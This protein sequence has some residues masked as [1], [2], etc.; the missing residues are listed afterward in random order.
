MAFQPRFQTLVDI[1]RHATKEYGQNPLFGVKKGGTW[2]WSTYAEFAKSVDALRGGLA[3]VGVVKGDRVA[4]IANNRPEWAI[5]AYASYGLGAQFVPMYESQLDKDWKFILENCGAKVVFAANEGIRDRIQSFRGDLPKLEQLVVIDGKGDDNS[6]GWEDLLA[7]GE[8]KPAEIV[9]VSPDD[10]AGFIYTSGTTGMPKGVL[11]THKNLAYNVSAIHDV[12]P[13]SA[14]DRSL[15]FLPWAHSFGQTVELHGLFSMGASLGI[16]EAVDK[17]IVNLA[18]VQPTLLVSVPRIFNKIYDGLQKRMADEGGVK[19][20]LFD[21]AIANEDHRRAL[22]A[23]SKSSG[24]A[25]FKHGIFDKL[26]FSKV[27]DRFGGRLKY[28][29]SGG[30][31]INKDIA[32]FIDNLGITVYEGYGLTETSPIATANWPGSRRI[33]SI[34]KPIPGVEVKIDKEVTK[35]PVNGE[36]VVYGHNIMKGYN[37]LPEEDAKVFTDDG[38]FRTGD[39]GRI[40]DDGFVYITGRIKEQYKLENG[41]YVVPGPLEEQLK[42]SPFIASVM[43][44]GMNK[45]FNVA[46]IVPDM[47]SLEKWGKDN[48]ITGDLLTDP[49]V[50]ELMTKELDEHSSGF[51]QFEKVRKFKLIAEDFTTENDMLTPTMKLKRRIV[52]KAYG[53]DLDALYG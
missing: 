24:W 44:N 12:F 13:M 2:N 5:G 1:Y 18:E 23:E 40:D 45:P 38:G 6:I 51:K 15:S 36:I 52:M 46:I 16:A 14:D 3:D 8:E 47:V 10:V 22:A 30:A 9:D 35:D 25:D 17:I 28:A 19:K 31:A 27:R 20:A 50:A 7:R 48:G 53:D 34:G 42:L 39:M 11:L 4:I 33:G 21:A 37:E 41:K 29:F 32:I 49:K 43:I 26:V